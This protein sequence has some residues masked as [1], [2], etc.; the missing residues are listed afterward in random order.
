M[1]FQYHRNHAGLPVIEMQQVRFKIHLRSQCLQDS[2]LEKGKALN[3]EA[4]VYV[5]IIM[6]EV[7]FVIDQIDGKPVQVKA[8]EAAVH[9]APAQF[10][11]GPAHKGEIFKIVVF[12]LTI[13]RKH[14]TYVMSFLTQYLRQGSYD[15]S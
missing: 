8:E 11:H 13:K 1:R 4:V 10:N 14:N 9:S 12:Y 7:E 6:A 15:I 5:E 2:P 3:I